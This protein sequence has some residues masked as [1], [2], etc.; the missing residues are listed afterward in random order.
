MVPFL[1]KLIQI[2]LEYSF[3]H[4]LQK[5]LFIFLATHSKKE[6]ISFSI[7]STTKKST[8]PYV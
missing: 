8:L 7:H 4:A 6:Y 5:H 2:N 3:P 1:I